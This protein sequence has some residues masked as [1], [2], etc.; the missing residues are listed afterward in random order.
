MFNKKLMICYLR[1]GYN[2]EKGI[3]LG[4]KY[5]GEIILLGIA[6]SIIIDIITAVSINVTNTPIG[7]AFV[8]FIK[9]CGT[10]SE[11]L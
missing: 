9:T 2:G 5:S 6:L 4:K 7:H 8:N 11:Y 1:G 10:D 3:A